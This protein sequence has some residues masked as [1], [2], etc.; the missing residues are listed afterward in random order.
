[1]S[2]VDEFEDDWYARVSKRPDACPECGTTAWMPTL[3]RWVCG[4]KWEP[5][6]YTGSWACAEIKKL[7]SRLTELEP[8]LTAATDWRDVEMDD[9]Y[10]TGDATFYLN[11]LADAVDSLPERQQDEVATS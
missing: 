5:M 3:G 2:E 1:M 8:V 11:A 9:N 6:S 10:S 7:R 4:A